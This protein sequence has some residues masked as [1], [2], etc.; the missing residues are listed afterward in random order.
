MLDL[1]LQEREELLEAAAGWG[2]YAAHA[3]QDAGIEAQGGRGLR[4]ARE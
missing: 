4:L 1:R 2:P 3:S